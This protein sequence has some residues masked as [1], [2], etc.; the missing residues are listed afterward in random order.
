[1]SSL[2]KAG[3]KEKTLLKYMERE[4]RKGSEEYWQEWRWVGKAAGLDADVKRC[5]KIWEESRCR[6][7]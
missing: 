7:L 6:N 5:D 3:R 1:M 4:A 2:Y